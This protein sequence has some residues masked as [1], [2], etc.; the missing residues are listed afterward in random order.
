MES[1]SG[2]Q[3]ASPAWKLALLG[4]LAV[5][6]VLQVV[7]H[8]QTDLHAQLRLSIMGNIFLFVS[9]ISQSLYLMRKST[10]WGIALLIF[11]SA[12]LAYGLRVLLRVL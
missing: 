6:I 9:L 5:A 7:S 11:T 4:P 3:S 10:R 2:S 8:R 12:G 1:T